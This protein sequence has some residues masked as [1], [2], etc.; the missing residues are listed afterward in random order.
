[1]IPDFSPNGKESGRKKGG[2]HSLPP[3][4]G[5]KKQE[6]GTFVRIFLSV[7]IRMVSKGG[8]D[9]LRALLSTSS[10]SLAWKASKDMTSC[11]PLRLRTATSPVSTS[12][13]PTT[14]I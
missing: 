14:S 5:A 1:M 3:G 11:S 8:G 9:Q 12:L 2:N 7:L 10:F 13:S 6:D 4:D